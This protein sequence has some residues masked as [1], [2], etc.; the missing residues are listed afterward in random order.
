MKKTWRFYTMSVFLLIM[1]F[2][3]SLAIGAETYD[4]DGTASEEF[5]F[6]QVECNRTLILNC[7][8]EEGQLIKQ[9]SYQTKRGVEELIS[10]GLNG[11]DLVAF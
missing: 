2:V 1:A 11:Y 6:D 3:F 8:D 10:F 5:L 4:P 7:V 9:V